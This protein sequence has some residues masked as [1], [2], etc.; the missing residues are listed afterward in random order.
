M[1]LTFYRYNGS[2]RKVNKKLTDVKTVP[3]LGIKNDTS[4]MSPTFILKTDPDVYTSNYVYCDT[5]NRYYYT[6]DII[7]MTGGR[8]ALTCD[9]DVLYT[10]K[11]QILNSS[12]WVRR[13]GTKPPDSD[14]MHQDYPFEQRCDIGRIEFP[15]ANQ[16]FD[17]R[18]QTT[19]A[20]ICVINFI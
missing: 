12:G 9:I 13:S 6:R 20:K 19:A 15:A 18:G 4:L 17:L 3:L 2:P 14:F 1:Q 11:D 7:A 16:Y 5:T 10:Y 8:I